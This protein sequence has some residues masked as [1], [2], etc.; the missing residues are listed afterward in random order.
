MLLAV[1]DNENN[2]ETEND[3]ISTE[4]S[5]IKHIYNTLLEQIDLG[6]ISRMKRDI[7]LTKLISMIE[8]IVFYE[9]FNIS[10]A[11]KKYITDKIAQKFNNN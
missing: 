9:Q 3:E 8:E 11:E 4:S 2:L 1:R 6:M 10:Y 7:L 5:V